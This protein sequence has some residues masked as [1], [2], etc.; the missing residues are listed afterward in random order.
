M[1]YIVLP[2]AMSSGSSKVLAQALECKRI[3]IKRNTY[4]GFSNHVVINWGS[5]KQLP[6]LNNCHSVLNHPRY[7]RNASHK[8]TSFKLLTEAGVP[9]MAYTT[10]R[11]QAYRWLNENMAVFS[12][13]LLSAN[14]GKGIVV[15]KVEDRYIEPA[16]LYTQEFKKTREYRVHIFQGQLVCIQQKKLKASENRSEE[17]DN[18]VWNHDKGQRVFARFNVDMTDDLKQELIDISSRAIEALS[19]DFGAVDIGWN[20]EEGCKVFEVNTGFGLV[21]TTIE[22]WKKVFTNYLE[23]L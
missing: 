14:S 19:L 20:E 8:L 23:T 21:G 17:P 16:P 13:T 22:D 3:H 9:T 6:S 11:N 5:Q 1:K 10:S 18:Y 7:I 12:R 2:Y 4:R 15:N